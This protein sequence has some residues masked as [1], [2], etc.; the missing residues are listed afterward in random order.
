MSKFIKMKKKAAKKFLRTLDS[1][2]EA[3]DGMM[4]L[5][6][7]FPVNNL[8]EEDQK[9]LEDMTIRQRELYNDHAQLA[10]E[11]LKIRSKYQL[12]DGEGY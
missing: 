4:Q 10:F 2:E 11:A 9:L 1:L 12:Y 3:A 5:L 6:R 8:S 7:I